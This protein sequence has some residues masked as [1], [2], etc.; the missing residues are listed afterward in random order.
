MRDTIT[1]GVIAGTSATAAMTLF[2]SA[3]RLFGL[4]FIS[5]WETAAHIFLNPQLIHTPIGYFIGYTGQFVLGSIFGI[6]V[7]YTLRMTGKDF[8]L[9]KGIGIGAVVWLASIG[10]FM[11]V[12]HIQLQ[13]RS[14]PLT[15]LITVGQFNI[16]GIISSIIIARY[17]RFKIK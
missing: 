10:L 7:A 16:M 15:N 12:L 1:I 6:V 13:G 17:G 4:D 11:R 14:E 2:N 5:T 3:L 8:Y 9:L